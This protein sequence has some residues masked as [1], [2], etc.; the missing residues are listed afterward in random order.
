MKLN[1][2]RS[3]GSRDMERTGNGRGFSLNIIYCHIC[4]TMGLGHIERGGGRVTPMILNDD[5]DLESADPV[6]RFYTLS[7]SH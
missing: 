6:H 7:L 1:E 5:R 3:K 2:N 4:T